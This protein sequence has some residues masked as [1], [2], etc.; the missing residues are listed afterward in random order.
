EWWRNR[1]AAVAL[2]PVTRAVRVQR[3]GVRDQLSRAAAA[4]DLQFGPDV[5][6]SSRAILGGMIGNNSA[7]SRPIVYG[8]TIDHVRRLD[9]VLAEGTRL[10]FDALSPAEWE[11]KAGRP[12]REG[13]LYRDVRAI[14]EQHRSQL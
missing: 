13:R 4:H 5:S 10:S 14:V 2:A 1:S 7:G 11:E 8:K 3:G 9:V 6:T 12:T